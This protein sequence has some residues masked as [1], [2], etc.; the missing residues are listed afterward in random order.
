MMVRLLAMVL[1]RNSQHVILKSTQALPDYPA[2]R[3]SPDEPV[4]PATAQVADYVAWNLWASINRQLRFLQW[5]L[6]LSWMYC[7]GG[8]H[9]VG[10]LVDAAAACSGCIWSASLDN[11]NL[12]TG[13]NWRTVVF[14]EIMDVPLPMWGGF[15]RGKKLETREHGIS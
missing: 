3:Q 1:H 8:G 14:Y 10:G 11:M 7:C 12:K 4:F 2:A 13:R 15:E 6:V 9:W 5:T